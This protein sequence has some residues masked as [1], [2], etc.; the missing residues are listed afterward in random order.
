MIIAVL[1]PSIALLRLARRP[2]GTLTLVRHGQAE[3]D[4]TRTFTGWADPDLSEPGALQAKVAAKALQEYGYTF[5]IAYTSNLKRAIHTTWLLLK[6]LDL[7]HLGVYK[8][9]KLN[10]RSVGALTGRTVGD[11]V[12]LYGEEALASW[13]RSFHLR[14]PSYTDDHP[15]F[16]ARQ[17]KFERWQDKRGQVLPVTPPPSESLAE[18]AARCRAVWEQDILPDLE[19]GKNVLVVAHG[20][21]IRGLVMAIDGLGEESFASLEVPLFTPLVYKFER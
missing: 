6:E 5:D 9:Y 15:L 20:N 11:M 8:D 14:P 3:W 12:D 18:V 1:L 21:S 19:D 13:R 2:P 17:E 16:S 4:P 7:I 10:E